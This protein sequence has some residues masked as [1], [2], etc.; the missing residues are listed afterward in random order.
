MST[1]PFYDPAQ[2]VLGYF[3]H[4]PLGLFAGMTSASQ[5]MNEEQAHEL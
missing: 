5:N 2:S 3:E 1:E 4:D